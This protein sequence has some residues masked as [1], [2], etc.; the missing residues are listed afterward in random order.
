MPF[1]SPIG[2]D[3][4]KEL[5][6]SGCT[7]V[8]KTLFIEDVIENPGKVQLIL[9]PRRFGKTLNMSLVAHFFDCRNDHRYLFKGLAIE[10]RPCFEMCGSH[11]VLFLNFKNLNERN[12]SDFVSRYR[13]MISELYIDHD[14]LLEEINPLRRDRFMEYAKGTVDPVHLKDALKWLSQRLKE[15][16]GKGVVL[17]IDEYDSPINEGY[18]R[19][20]YAEMID[21]MR[22]VLSS[23]LKTNDALE[24]AVLTGILRV[25]KE[26]IFS[27]LNH[28]KTYS[29][30]SEAFADKFGFTERETEALLEAGNRVEHLQTVQDWYNGYQVGEE[31]IYNP[32]SLLNY[33]GES[34]K[35]CMPYW[36][37]TSANVLIQDQLI[38]ASGDAQEQLKELMNGRDLETGISQQTVFSDL[39]EDPQNLWSLLLFSGYL[40]VSRSW[41]DDLQ[42]RYG[43][44]IPNKE[45]L[46]L[47]HTTFQGW[48]RTQLGTNKTEA[49]LKALTNGDIASFGEHLGTLIVATLSY[50]DTTGKTPERVYHTFV[51]G[52]L[53]QLSGRYHIRSNRE[54]GMGRYDLM[55]IPKD[56]QGRGI[57]MEFKTAATVDGLD[58][59]L[60]A[61]L[62]Q[63]AEQN[64]RAELEAQ[65]I[66][67]ISEIAVAFCG[68]QVR[69]KE[70]ETIS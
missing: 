9:R 36:V 4:F 43:L 27:G 50:Y 3:N 41:M 58:D 32:W 40:T 65:G 35:D 6:E 2:I 44:R 51:L 34:V 33:L 49:M 26:S 70:R 21:F 47:Y 17:L 55:M 59:A 25:S 31:T 53:A 19:N 12:F 11:P 5:I 63:I 48:L 28:V 52:L 29:V 7:Y 64:Y 57:V 10:K 39:Q 66:T 20:Y 24:R 13:N 37:N 62:D 22:E 30:L 46:S 42:P 8:D 56:P 61:G 68:K 60:Q 69:L 67:H 1:K 45:V 23:V 14:Y 38:H 15:Y 18:H 16:H 54:S